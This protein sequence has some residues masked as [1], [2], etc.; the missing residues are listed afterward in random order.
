MTDQAQQQRPGSEGIR[1]LDS[2]MHASRRSAICA[3]I[4]DSGQAI[5]LLLTAPER[6]SD[7]E[8]FSV[9]LD[10]GV[11]RIVVDEGHLL[12][13]WGSDFRPLYRRIPKVIQSLEAKTDR[14]I[15]VTLFSATFRKQ[16]FADLE[17]ILGRSIV[18]NWDPNPNPAYRPNLVPEIISASV[19]LPTNKDTRRLWQLEQLKDQL[20][21]DLV[22][23]PSH[24]VLIFV[25]KRVDAVLWALALRTVLPEFGNKIL[26]YFSDIPE[27]ML[28]DRE[29]NEQG[30]LRVLVTTSAF[31]MG[32]DNHE[33]HAVYH[34]ELPDSLTDYVQECGRAG[35]HPEP[36]VPGK[37]VLLFPG[38]ADPQHSLHKSALNAISKSAIRLTSYVEEQWND[39]LE[40]RHPIVDVSTLVDPQDDPSHYRRWL[41]RAEEL[42]LGTYL[43]NIP[44]LLRLKPPFPDQSEELLKQEKNRFEWRDDVDPERA[45][46]FMLEYRRGIRN[47][48]YPIPT[49]V[50][51]PDPLIA[52]ASLGGSPDKDDFIPDPAASESPGEKLFS[53]QCLREALYT[54]FCREDSPPPHC[55]GEDPAYLC[56]VCKSR[57]EDPDFIDS[58]PDQRNRANAKWVTL[59]SQFFKLRSTPDKV[60][61]KEIKLIPTVSFRKCLPYIRQP[62][63]EKMLKHWL[64]KNVD[65][66]DNS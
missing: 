26:P 2:L 51:S 57:T 32:I 38:P 65:F 15:P 14:S 17:R 56:T 13:N 11:A 25:R 55:Q 37:H 48:L 29:F 58:K 34:L 61:E 8:L 10:R 42:G 66:G 27:K 18:Q 43:G 49:G 6:L 12:G 36:R 41:V 21:Q 39:F 9:L 4:V 3:E 30:S 60:E 31:G 19:D 35:R 22:L 28:I 52:W 53:G 45:W 1:S 50:G 44:R 24:K 5:H 33:I 40:S 59:A 62:E 54:P 63:Y 64:F 23:N 16:D 7:P 20:R 46:E 47:R